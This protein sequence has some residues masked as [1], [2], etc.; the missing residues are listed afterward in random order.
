[1]DGL[2]FDHR[3]H[4]GHRGECGAPF[5]ILCWIQGAASRHNAA[6]ANPGHV[7]ILERGVR[8]WNEWR[9]EHAAMRPELGGVDISRANFYGALLNHADLFRANLHK[10]DLRGATLGHASLIEADLSGA[11]L[12]GAS[13]EEADLTGANL[14]GVKLIDTNLRGAKIKLVSLIRGDLTG[15]DLSGAI[16]SES[17]LRGADL[18]RARL[19]EAE[20]REIDLSETDLTGAR[21][22]GA[23]MM[24]T[25]LRRANLSSTTVRGADF[26]Y[27]VAGWTLFVD[28]D[29]RETKGLEMVRHAGPSHI[30]IDT[31]YKS[32]GEIPE[33]FLRAAGVPDGFI[34]YMRSLTGKAIEFY[35]CFI[36]YSTKDQE[37]AE[38]LYAD[39]QAN[40]VRC[41]FAPHDI[42]G[43]KKIHEQIDEAIRVHDKLLLI[44]SPDSI[45]SAWVETEIAKARKRE[46]RDGRRVLFPV[47]LVDFETLKSWECFDAD[48]G[49]DSAREIREYY[50]PDFSDWKNHDSYQQAF[51]R[52]LKD[53][54]AE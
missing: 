41:W 25:N 53:L 16:L 37:F 17:D 46:V 7:A 5:A 52:L 40:N 32:G 20:L 45:K 51:Q 10:A 42:Q 14:N 36:S 43:G 29:F 28:V 23:K 33:V 11:D 44:L 35:S 9:G 22:D 27:A 6:M 39:L 15:A 2:L 30:G 13:I 26:S 1:L 34:T 54:K 38:R 19:I 8:V 47:R 21:L 4:E 24:E 49:K 3:G 50:T 18:K 48:T 31:I 12:S